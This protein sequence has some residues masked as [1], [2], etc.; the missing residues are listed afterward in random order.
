[1]GHDLNPPIKARFVRIIP[2]KWQTYIAMR[3]EFYGCHTSKIRSFFLFLF[4]HN[5]FLLTERKVWYHERISVEK[6]T[7]EINILPYR[8]IKLRP[9]KDLGPFENIEPQKVK[10][11]SIVRQEKLQDQFVFYS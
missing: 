2:E 3:A 8:S 11:F 6:A 10:Q 9:R 1:M 5:L 7:I 4:C